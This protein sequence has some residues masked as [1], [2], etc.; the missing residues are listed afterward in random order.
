MNP[1]YEDCDNTEMLCCG[2]PILG[3]TPGQAGRGSEHLVEL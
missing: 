2:C 1:A 3:D